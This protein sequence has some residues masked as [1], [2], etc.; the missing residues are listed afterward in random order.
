MKSFDTTKLIKLTN[1]EV[2][3]D[4][5]DKFSESV[6]NILLWC[7]KLDNINTSSVT[8]MFGL[9]DVF[10]KG[11]ENLRPDV[12]TDGN[13]RENILHNCKDNNDMFI[14]VPKVIE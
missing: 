8:P 13:Y 3:E 11:L 5:L 9:F 7:A 10:E 4:V 14:C 1:I 12:V 2:E 6:T